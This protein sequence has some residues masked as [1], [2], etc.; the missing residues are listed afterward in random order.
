M[1]E[2][3]KIFWEKAPE[4]IYTVKELFVLFE[5][6]KTLSQIRPYSHVIIYI[7]DEQY[8]FNLTLICYRQAKKVSKRSNKNVLFISSSIIAGADAFAFSVIQYVLFEKQKGLKVL[9]KLQSAMKYIANSAQVKGFPSTGNLNEARNFLDNFIAELQHQIKIYQR[10]YSGISTNSAKKFVSTLTSLLS[11]HANVDKNTLKIGIESIRVNSNEVIHSEALSNEE[12]SKHFNF[13][14]T[15]FRQL[16]KI[17]LDECSFPQK[18]SLPEQDFWL[19]GDSFIDTKLNY[20]HDSSPRFIKGFDYSNGK[21]KDRAELLAEGYSWIQ[22]SDILRKY[23]H[24]LQQ[25]N[26]DKSIIKRRLATFACNAYFMH[27]LTLTGMN[28]SVASRLKFNHSYEIKPEAIHFKV[29]KYRAGNKKISFSIQS[30]F[31]EDF[32]LY[33][34]LREKLLTKYNSSLSTLFIKSVVYKVTSPD[35]DGTTTS[36]IRKLMKTL[37]GNAIG[38]TSRQLRVTKGVWVRSKYGEIVSAYSLQHN[39][40]TSIKSYT[41]QTEEK[42]IDELTNYFDKLNT[43][44]INRK[45]SAIDITEVGGC[46]DKYNPSNRKNTGIP[47]NCIENEGCLFCDKYRIHA[48]E[49]DIRKLLSLKYVIEQS[50]SLSKSI[51]QFN[52]FFGLVLERIDEL[53]HSLKN[54]DPALEKKILRVKSEVFEYGKLTPYWIRKIELLDTLGVF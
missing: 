19:I 30:E 49:I 4:K 11:I 3:K 47:S 16:A 15:M 41:S 22:S 32:K 36:K 17:I 7:E 43:K 44:V 20:N 52:Q 1:I 10:H 2:N 50:R 26:E 29:I 48:D 42:I 27:F 37:T 23:K 54:A 53:L 8:C 13:Y 21:P 18:L 34:K 46:S 31:I 40:G 24:S 39:V 38:G 6:D 14:T 5:Q 45:D 9:Q 28:D 51:E 25:A 12:L 33:L 35:T